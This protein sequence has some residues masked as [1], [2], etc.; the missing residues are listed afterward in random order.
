M[1]ADL[2]SS[3]LIGGSMFSWQLYEEDGGGVHVFTER[4]GQKQVCVGDI[5]QLAKSRQV[6]K[7]VAADGSPQHELDAQRIVRHLDQVARCGCV[8]P[9]SSAKRTYFNIR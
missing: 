2:R 6:L 9:C 5:E 4:T 3:A 1:N 7:R 8:V